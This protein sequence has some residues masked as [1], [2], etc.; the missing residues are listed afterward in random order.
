MTFVPCA[1]F[2]LQCDR[3]GTVFDDEYEVHFPVPDPAEA[4]LVDHVEAFGWTTDGERWHCACC[5]ELHSPLCRA[6]WR[7]QRRDC[8]DP[9]CACT[10]RAPLDGQGVLPGTLEA[11]RG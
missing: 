5:P 7:G 1:C 2:V 10:L 11:S 3:C 9:D 6:C 8:E 4:A